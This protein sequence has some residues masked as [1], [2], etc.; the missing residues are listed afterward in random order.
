MRNPKRELC[1]KE[2]RSSST[3]NLHTKIKRELTPTQSKVALPS[4][5]ILAKE[6]LISAV[7]TLIKNK[8]YSILNVPKTPNICSA[9]SESITPSKPSELSDIHSIS[10][11]A[12][13]RRVSTQSDYKANYK[14]DFKLSKQNSRIRIA[15]RY[16]R[17]PNEENLKVAL[18]EIENNPSKKFL[19]YEKQEKQG[20]VLGKKSDIEALLESQGNLPKINK[21]VEKK[22]EKIKAEEIKEQIKEPIEISVDVESQVSDPSPVREK[23]FEFRRSNTPIRAKRVEKNSS[24]VLKFLTKS[25]IGR[26]FVEKYQNNEDFSVLNQDTPTIIKETV[27]RTLVDYRQESL[28]ILKDTSFFANKIM[29][30]IRCPG[31]VKKCYYAN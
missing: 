23:K 16:R 20:P 1:I 19:T 31:R 21:S 8:R 22:V 2:A 13:T 24:K 25:K 30:A 27:N 12:D 4:K 3:N 18:K 11:V 5:S 7:N 29:K 15:G 10:T 6:I 14:V 26:E 9:T 28:K 17:N